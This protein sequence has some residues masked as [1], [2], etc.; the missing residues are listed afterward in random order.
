[1][2]GRTISPSAPSFSM[3]RAYRQARAVLHSAT[4]LSTGTRPPLTFIASSI[5]RRFSSGS[6]AVFSPSDPSMTSPATPD[7]ISASRCVAVASRSSDWSLRNCVVTAGKTPCHAMFMA[8]QCTA[9]PPRFPAR[10]RPRVPPPPAVQRS[11]K[12]RG[13]RGPTGG[14]RPLPKVTPL[15]IGRDAATIAPPHSRRREMTQTDLM[16]DVLERNLEMVKAT[17]ADFSDADMLARPVPAAN[18]AAWQL[19]HLICSEARMVAAAK[20]AAPALPPGFETKFT[21]ETSKTDDPNF[22]PRKSELLD[23]FAKTR[24]ASVQWVR[25][26]KESDLAQPTPE[27][28]HR[29]AP[30]VAHLAATMP[31]HVAMHT[32]QFQV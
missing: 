28:L 13:P 30:T 18:H 16:A 14:V 26:L 21:P 4:P 7:S 11:T 12:M 17:L 10:G 6:S 27:R 2:A 8:G 29:F 22:F 1:M 24:A 5:T 15:E 32:G 31:V 25:T 19:G 20:N 3:S 9:M 23:Q